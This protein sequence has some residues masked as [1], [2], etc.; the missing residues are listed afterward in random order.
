MG[1]LPRPTWRGVLGETLGLP[2]DLRRLWAAAGNR[3][4]RPPD[5]VGAGP[6]EVS[7]GIYGGEYLPSW[8]ARAE[9]AARRWGTPEQIRD[10]ALVISQISSHN[11]LAAG[12]LCG[13]DKA[14]MDDAD[15]D[16]WVTAPSVR[17]AL[18]DAN[19][20]ATERVV[21]DALGL[22]LRVNTTGESHV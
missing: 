14:R 16:V 22:Q 19:A 12:L 18:L 20:L 3:E 6:V 11:E 7:P 10:W 21:R 9:R 5:A 17:A 1:T 15:L 4:K 13:V 8:T 2:G